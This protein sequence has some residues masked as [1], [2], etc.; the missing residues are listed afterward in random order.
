MG[1][2]PLPEMNHDDPE[3][4]RIL[5]PIL[6]RERVLF[7]IERLSNVW[8]AQGYVPRYLE[9]NWDRSRATI[10]RGELDPTLKEMV[11]VTTSAYNSCDY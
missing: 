5:K 6:R 7:G 4:K 3:V 8:L 10:Q 9:S 2:I 11:A 1:T